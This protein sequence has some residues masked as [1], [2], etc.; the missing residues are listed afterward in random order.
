M[1]SQRLML[2]K[3]GIRDY[4]SHSEIAREVPEE[5][6]ELMFKSL[7]MVVASDREIAQEE[8]D[9]LSG[10]SDIWELGDAGNDMFNDILDKFANL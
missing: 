2:E 1:V 4:K 9:I 3:M 5:Y 6:R 8:L 10:L 7:S